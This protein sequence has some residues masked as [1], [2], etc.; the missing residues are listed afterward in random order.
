M[1][2]TPIPCPDFGTALDTLLAARSRGLS[3]SYHPDGGDTA[4]FSKPVTHTVFVTGYETTV[5][6]FVNDHIPE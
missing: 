5:K 2:P 1:T 6:E 4:L 3:A